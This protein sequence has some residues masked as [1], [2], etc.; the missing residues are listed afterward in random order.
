MRNSYHFFVK[1]KK[2]TSFLPDFNLVLWSTKKVGSQ[3]RKWIFRLATGI[4]RFLDDA[5]IAGD[6]ATPLEPALTVD[7]LF[8]N[9][10]IV[11]PAA[12]K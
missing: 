1:K 12:T 11:T 8:N 4:D 5:G 2:K 3:L 6:L 10:R 7:L 9:F